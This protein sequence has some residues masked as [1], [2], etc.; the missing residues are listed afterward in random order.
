MEGGQEGGGSRRLYAPL[1]RLDPG[2]DPAAAVAGDE[3]AA[4]EAGIEAAQVVAQAAQGLPVQVELL[5]SL[6]HGSS[7]LGIGVTCHAPPPP[8]RR[9]PTLRARGGRGP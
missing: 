4:V 8:W 9:D 7:S 5:D 1:R 2:R 6:R 3:I